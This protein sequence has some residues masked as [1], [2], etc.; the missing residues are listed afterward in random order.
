MRTST[1]LELL[2]VTGSDSLPSTVAV[3]ASVPRAAPAAT[4]TG[5][6]NAE[7]P[8]TVSRPPE[9]VTV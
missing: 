5:I 4:V 8:P 7:V 2:D 1:E 6:V 3:L 9:H